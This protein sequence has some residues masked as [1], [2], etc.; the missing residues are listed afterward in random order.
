MDYWHKIWVCPYFIWDDRTKIGCEGKITLK[1]PDKKSLA[2][3]ADR[4]CCSID[5]YP[6]CPVAKMIEEKYNDEKK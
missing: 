3:Y 4:F 6:N 2:E 5:N 1:F